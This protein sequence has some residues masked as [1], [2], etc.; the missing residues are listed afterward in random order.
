M[1]C[2]FKHL[3]NTEMDSW[4]TEEGE[5]ILSIYRGPKIYII[6]LS[7]FYKNVYCT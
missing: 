5:N 4:A 3:R 2:E 6:D 7:L 1:I